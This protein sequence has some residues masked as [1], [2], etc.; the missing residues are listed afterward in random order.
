MPASIMLSPAEEVRIAV[1]VAAEITPA[2]VAAR[3][4]NALSFVEAAAADALARVDACNTTAAATSAASAAATSALLTHWQ[5]GFADSHG[6]CI[7][8]RTLP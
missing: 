4:R 8:Y 5:S 2:H 1:S 7:R 6:E 3:A